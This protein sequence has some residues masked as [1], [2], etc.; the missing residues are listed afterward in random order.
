MDQSLVG[1]IATKLLLPASPRHYVRRPRLDH[2]LAA[3]SRHKLTLVAAPAGYGKTALV[4]SW[5]GPCV[6]HRVGWR[7]LEPRED[8][9]SRFWAYLCGALERLGVPIPAVDDVVERSIADP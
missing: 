9:P 3:G 8:A 5:L 7:A 1:L 4:T 6:H 2:R